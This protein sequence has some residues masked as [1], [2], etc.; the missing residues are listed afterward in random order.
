M[1]PTQS[2]MFNPMLCIAFDVSY[3]VIDT[4]LSLHIEKREPHRVSEQ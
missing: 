1:T 4:F 2:A 3:F